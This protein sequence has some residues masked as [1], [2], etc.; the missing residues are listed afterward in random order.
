[1][2]PRGHTKWLSVIP[3]Q[4]TKV[5]RDGNPSS[6]LSPP[7]LV[8][9]ESRTFEVCFALYWAGLALLG[10]YAI[11]VLGAALPPRLLDPAWIERVCGS[12][13]GGVS[14]PIIALVLILLGAYL[15]NPQRSSTYLPRLSWLSFWVAL[16][17]FLMIP[18]QT[19]ATVTLLGRIA[20]QEQQQLGVFSR[21]LERIRLSLSEAQLAGAIASIPGA[22]VI[23][24]GS[25]TVP[26]PQARQMLIQQI[27]PQL[28]LRSNQLKA[29]SATRWREAMP[30]MFKDAVVAIFSALSF[31]AIGRN[32]P[33]GPTLL[34]RILFPGMNRLGIVDPHVQ[35]LLDLE[36]A[37][38]AGK[39]TDPQPGE[40]ADQEL[41]QGPDAEPQ[42][43]PEAAKGLAPRPWTEGVPGPPEEEE[44][45]QP[46]KH[47]P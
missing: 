8:S 3:K 15:D 24:P 23:T 31:A 32:T 39:L 36:E 20:K 12:L 38:A 29:E 6:R 25:L 26:L 35:K 47:Y 16:G 22:P 18:L 34:E 17:F 27:E 42:K 46:E 37:K 13:R 19:W 28:R 30:R 9:S 45:F 11:T 44:D 41:P 21:G 4:D 43:R 40:E 33:D 1:M 7:D 5:P 14:F 2:V 10:I